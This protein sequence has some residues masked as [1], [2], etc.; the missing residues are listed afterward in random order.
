MSVFTI[1][2]PCDNEVVTRE[3][4]LPIDITKENIDLFFYRLG[5]F[6]E[7]AQ[8]SMQAIMSTDPPNS[9]PEREAYFQEHGCIMPED[10]QRLALTKD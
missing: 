3:I 6:F 9:D 1:S 8:C 7:L 5:G 10:E 2:I 4:E